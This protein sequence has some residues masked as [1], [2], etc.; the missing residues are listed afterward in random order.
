M[1][2]GPQSEKQRVYWDSRGFGNRQ[3]L[4]IHRPGNALL[5]LC[6]TLCFVFIARTP[7]FSCVTMSEPEDQLSLNFPQFYPAATSSLTVPRLIGAS[8]HATEAW[9]LHIRASKA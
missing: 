1:Q 4:K 9:G 7:L 6:R 8:F 5:T 3:L 2:T